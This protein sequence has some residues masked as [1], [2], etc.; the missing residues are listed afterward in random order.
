MPNDEYN[1]YRYDFV[2]GFERERRVE[3]LSSALAEKQDERWISK[4]G[5]LSEMVE[6][7]EIECANLLQRSPIT[8]ATGSDNTTITVTLTTA[9][10]GVVDFDGDTLDEGELVQIPPL[11][12]DLLALFP[13]YG[14]ILTSEDVNENNQRYIGTCQAFRV[15]S[16][17]DHWLLPLEDAKKCIYALPMTDLDTTKMS[18]QFKDK[19]PM[20]LVYWKDHSVD[21]D[22]A[23]S[24]AMNYAKGRLPFRRNPYL[25]LPP[26]DIK[27]KKTES[28]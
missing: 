21:V 9:T 12:N 11:G 7:T 16:G 28:A 22:N 15:W 18:Y 2:D 26:L 3:F 14:H 5:V 6:V 23:K 4:D 1:T 27:T 20:I 10:E 17:A 25:Y 19:D 24:I 13:K 8:N